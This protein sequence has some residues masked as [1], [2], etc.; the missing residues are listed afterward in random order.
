MTFYRW[1]YHVALAQNT[2]KHDY[3]ENHSTGTI[4]VALRD[5]LFLCVGMVCSCLLVESDLFVWCSIKI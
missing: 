3:C 4:G 1:D 2:L 5:S